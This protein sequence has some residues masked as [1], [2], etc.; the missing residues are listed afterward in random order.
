MAQA[1]HI[2]FFIKLI[3][4]SIDV[5]GARANPAEHPLY[6]LS[7]RSCMTSACSSSCAPRM[8]GFLAGQLLVNKWQ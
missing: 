6:L 1:N 4:Q 2:R 8:Q 5:T 7:P 3:L